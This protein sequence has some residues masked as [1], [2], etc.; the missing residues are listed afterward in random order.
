[1]NRGEGC[2]AFMGKREDFI[3]S[4]LFRRC[5]ATH[6]RFVVFGAGVGIARQVFKV[7]EYWELMLRLQLAKQGTRFGSSTTWRFG[8]C[9][10]SKLYRRAC[11]NIFS[12]DYL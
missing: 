8:N 2:S 11:F 7:T 1:M 12:K 6:W 3:N 4:I 9:G 5:A 10:G